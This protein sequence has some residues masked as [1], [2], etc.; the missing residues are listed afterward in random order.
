MPTEYPRL[1]WF[2]AVCFGF[3]Y[4]IDTPK[5][6]GLED[7]KWSWESGSLD[8]IR[9]IHF[10][11]IIL[12][13]PNLKGWYLPQNETLGGFQCE[14]PSNLWLLN[15]F[16]IQQNSFII[17][18]Q[19]PHCSVTDI[20]QITWIS[21]TQW[22]WPPHRGPPWSCSSELRTPMMPSG[23]ATMLQEVSR[24]SFARPKGR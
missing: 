21:S 10:W 2:M 22:T 9:T 19:T 15:I 20:V 3:G 24:P 8:Y 18:N 12:K 7:K 16:K 23:M 11:A 17:L 1:V 4:I 5:N 6:G 14:D 13:D